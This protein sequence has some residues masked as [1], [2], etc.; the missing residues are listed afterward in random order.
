MT[1]TPKP[2]GERTAQVAQ[3]DVMIWLCVFP[4]LTALEHGGPA[5][6]R[7]RPRRVGEPDRQGVRRVGEGRKRPLP[8]LARA[9]T[10]SATRRAHSAVRL[11]EPA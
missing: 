7:A 2:P 8:S 9:V 1:N 4:T 3:L 10:R 5:R 6:D 11:R